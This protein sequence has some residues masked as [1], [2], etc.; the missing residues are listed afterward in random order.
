MTSS[1]RKAERWQTI[2]PIVENI[3]QL[4]GR[5]PASM[6]GYIDKLSQAK[7]LSSDNLD[8]LRN[9]TGEGEVDWQRLQSGRGAI[10]DRARGT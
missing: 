9:L 2:G 10:R 4:G 6:Q 7:L 3:A 8:I 5:L 1:R